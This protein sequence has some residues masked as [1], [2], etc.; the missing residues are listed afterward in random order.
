MHC[1]RSDI[2]LSPDGWVT[3]RQIT[4]ARA[5]IGLA[6]GESLCIL[7]PS[8]KERRKRLGCRSASWQPPQGAC[9]FCCI[10]DREYVSSPQATFLQLASVVS[11]V[12][13]IEVGY[14]LCASFFIRN[15]EIVERTPV[16]NVERMREYI[17]KCTGV[18][19]CAKASE[20]LRYVANGAASPMEVKVSMLLTLPHKWGGYGLPIPVLNRPVHIPEELRD[21]AEK[22]YY[23]V[24][25]FWP[26]ALL[27]VEYDSDSNH[28]GADSLNADSKKRSYLDVLGVR[29]LSLTN[30]QVVDLD[31]MD[32]FVSA[33]ER[34]LAI[35]KRCTMKDFRERQ[36]TLRAKLLWNDPPRKFGESPQRLRCED[37][38]C[39]T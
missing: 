34:N 36:H 3:A 19:G 39:A 12:E 27:G 22:S 5:T 21:A 37:G 32:H 10:G 35:K 4:H 33:I 25:M 31:C 30:S 38:G 20:A 11:M 26:Q 8:V 29:V 9:S 18:R 7:T 14:E 24:D 13:L 16:T 2:E 1:I 28:S 6:C 15:G 23:L 17:G